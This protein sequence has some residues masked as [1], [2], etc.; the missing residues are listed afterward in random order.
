M[1]GVSGSKSNACERF[2]LL[3]AS[4]YMVVLA[5]SSPHP[6]SS[7]EKENAH[8]HLRLV[9]YNKPISNLR[10]LSRTEYAVAGSLGQPAST[11]MHFTSLAGQTLPAE[12]GVIKLLGVD[13]VLLANCALCTEAV[14][15]RLIRRN[16]EV[17]VSE[18]LICACFYGHAFGALRVC[19]NNGDVRES[20]KRGSTVQ[21]LGGCG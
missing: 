1:L 9:Y 5:A 6:P 17:S 14:H 18:R 4:I 19:P 7:A 20:S 8:C 3:I 13:T 10:T 2:K 16:I 15:V 21:L 12:R 11:E